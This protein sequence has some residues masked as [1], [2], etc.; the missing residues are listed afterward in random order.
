M[1]EGR[2]VLQWEDLPSGIVRRW[3]K[4]MYSAKQWL[5]NPLDDAEAHVE[6]TQSFRDAY[7]FDSFEEAYKV[8]SQCEKYFQDLGKD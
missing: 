5:E 7:V 4:R 1:S 6:V 3:F 8:I 2:Y